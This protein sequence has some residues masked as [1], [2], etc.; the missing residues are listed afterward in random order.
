MV[1]HCFLGE[2]FSAQSFDLIWMRNCRYFVP[3]VKQ[4]CKM[5]TMLPFFGSCFM[6]LYVLFWN[7]GAHGWNRGLG[8]VLACAGRRE[9]PI[10]IPPQM[11]GEKG[12]RKVRRVAA[13]EASQA[14]AWQKKNSK[15]GK[16][17]R[18]D[19]S[20]VG[21][22]WDRNDNIQ[23]HKPLA[24]FYCVKI[25]CPLLGP[26]SQF[27]SVLQMSSATP[28]LPWWQIRSLSEGPLARGWQMGTKVRSGEEPRWTEWGGWIGDLGVRGE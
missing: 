9:G 15:G 16:Q 21:K 22:Y 2:S 7:I 27:L 18:K 6:P 20:C 24:F 17:K 23:D 11:A 13:R 12:W 4:L 5:W 19:S 10:L 14:G 3:E 28:V 1:L 26:L 25:L 8:K